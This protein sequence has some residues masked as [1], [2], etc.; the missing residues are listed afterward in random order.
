M[1]YVVDKGNVDEAIEAMK[2]KFIIPNKTA[3][4]I[5]QLISNPLTTQITLFHSLR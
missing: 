4:N 3:I 5:L 1:I 2:I